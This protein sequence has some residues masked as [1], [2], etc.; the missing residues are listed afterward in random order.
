MGD[1]A[2]P[3]RLL[4]RRIVE[5][6]RLLRALDD[7]KAQVKMLI[8]GPG[9]GK[10]TLLEQW[11]AQE[12]RVVGWY[13]ARS[14][15]ADVAV[16]ARALV[17]AASSILPGV[18]RTLLDRLAITDD[19]QREAVLLA[20]ILALDLGDWPSAAWLAID[21]YHHLS[22]SPASEAFVECLWNKA[23]IRLVV[24]GE[25]RPAWA[26]GRMLLNRDVAEFGEGLLAMTQ[27]EVVAVARAQNKREDEALA[28]G[29]PIAIGLRAMLPGPVDLA[30]DIPEVVFE[31]LVEC[32]RDLLNEELAGDLVSVAALPWLDAEFLEE[33]LGSERARKV[34]RDAGGLGLLEYRA[35]RLELHELIAAHLQRY[36]IARSDVDEA[37]L[38]HALDIY[39]RRKD[40]DSVLE[41]LERTG[42]PD[43]TEDLLS[44]AV[45]DLLN[46]S[47]VATLEAY[48][49]RVVERTGTTGSIQVARAEIAL[50]HGEHLAAQAFAEDAA[51]MLPGEERA[52]ALCLA[53]AAAHV[54]SREARA[55]ELF[56]AAAQA[57]ETDEIGR[58]AWWGR[59]MAATALESPEAETLLAELPTSA[60]G[61]LEPRQAVREADKRIGLGMRFGAITT[62]HESRRVAELLPQV[63]DAMTRCSFRST[64]SCA[65]NLA[66][67]YATALAVAS[68]LFDESR[69][70]R[71]EFAQPYGSLMRGAAL[72][73]LHRFP[74]AHEAL[75]Q[76]SADAVRCNDTFGSQGVYAGRVRALLHE[77]RLTEAC[78]LEPPRVDDALP[79]M[80]GEVLASRALALACLGRIDEATEIAREARGATRAIEAQT[81]VRCVDAVC[82]VKLRSSN[83]YAALSAML[84]HAYSAGS[85][86]AVVTGYRA[87]GDLLDALMRSPTT[88]EV[89]GYVLTRAGDAVLARQLGVD[90]A[91][92]IDPIASLSTREKEVYELVC[93]GLSNAQIGRQLFISQLTVKVHVQ[94]LFDKLGVRSRTALALGAAHRRVQPAA[95]TDVT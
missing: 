18:G 83:L 75:D 6:P 19:P 34:I 89:T 26:S 95:E 88:A 86:D 40:W 70:L 58:R 35:E 79:G 65:L 20:E 22:R 82:A 4:R 52:R 77:G 51:E 62:L 24:A 2:P 15:G 25:T 43:V 36:D 46:L 60:Q 30:G 81:L 85:V 67:D 10:T 50:R 13:R 23:P 41:L 17:G 38:Q 90:P 64:Y 55:L 78:G 39:R 37:R 76:A 47:R 49:T 53:G 74:E 66:A 56:E 73:G 3:S 63:S 71:I 93:Q 59:L 28:D 21:D 11:A 80:R 31:Q 14:S 91:D 48:V 84:D 5:R 44:S 68:D 27:E 7:S 33:L 72:A 94:H 42:N 45:D 57:A 8:A 69:A 92:A 9:Y 87:N 54:G 32:V 12:G 16:V 61:R 1:T 29:W